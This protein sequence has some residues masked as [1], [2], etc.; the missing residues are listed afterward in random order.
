MKLILSAALFVLGCHAACHN[1]TRV[2]DEMVASCIDD[3]TG[4]EFEYVDVNKTM[5]TAGVSEADMPSMMYQYYTTGAGNDSSSDNTDV[6]KRDYYYWNVCSDNVAGRCDNHNVVNWGGGI[7]TY[8]TDTKSLLQRTQ[9]GRA[10][11]SPRSICTGFNQGTICVSWAAYYTENLYYYQT[12]DIATQCAETCEEQNESC[13][14]RAA[15]GGETKYFCV[16]NRSRG[17]GADDQIREC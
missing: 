8:K 13:L 3:D 12:T 11:K 2:D 16:S 10:N 6:E 9:N 14:A 7:R 15:S 17:C 5:E 4:F 1:M